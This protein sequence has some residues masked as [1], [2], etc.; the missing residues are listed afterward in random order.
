MPIRE[1]LS[2]RA[3][4]FK[5]QKSGLPIESYGLDAGEKVSNFFLTNAQLVQVNG[6]ASAYEE[7]LLDEP[8]G[9]TSLH[10]FKGAVVAQ[11]GTHLSVRASVASDAAIYAYFDLFSPPSTDHLVST[12]KLFSD[13]WRDRLVLTNSQDARY[14]S[15]TDVSVSLKWFGLDPPEVNAANGPANIFLP[16]AGGNVD[17]GELFY[18]FSLYDADTNTESPCMGSLPSAD[19]LFE[20]SP[21]GF[22]GPRPSSS[23]NNAGSTQ[24]MVC[25]GVTIKALVDAARLI[26]KFRATHFIVYRSGPKVGGLYSSF[27][28]VP[29]KDGGY[30][31]GN[32]IIPIVA[33]QGRSTGILNGQI[34]DFV[35]NTAAASLPAVS[36][37]ENNSPAPTPARLKKSLDFLR[38]Y[39]T[40][41]GANA[42]GP[43]E[44]WALTDYSG[45]RHVRFFRDQLFGIG[46]K[47][48]GFTVGRDISFSSDLKQKVTGLVTNFN[49][50]LHGSE[51]YQPDYFPYRWEVGVGDGQEATALGVLGDVALLCFKEG[52]TYY[53]TGSSPDNYVVRIMDTQKG[54]VHQSTVQETPI[55]VITL[56]RS[57]FILWNKIGQGTPIYDDVHNL[58]EDIHFEHSAQFYSSFDARLNLYRCS[59]AMTGA[60]TN[61][62][63]VTPNLTFVLD[64]NSMQWTI[65]EGSE[66]LCR[67]QFSVN[68]NNLAS[69]EG[70]VMDV[71]KVYDFVGSATNG[72]IF[73]YSMTDNVATN[74]SFPGSAP[75]IANYTSGT[76][77]FGDDQH[78]KRM[79]WVY[80]RAKSFTGWKVNIEII[81]D[82]DESR[83]FVLE[84]W[85]VVSSQSL[86]Y[87]SDVANDGSLLWDSGLGTDDGGRWASDGLVRQVSKIPVSCIGYT[88]QIRIIHQETDPTRYGFAIESLSAEAVQLGR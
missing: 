26:S 7:V 38:A 74:T 17:Q 6:A 24:V 25:L 52:S 12:Q 86:W 30:Y 55:G 21:N 2:S 49:S 22:L 57:G 53:L 41:L 71:G 81:P 27:F 40:Y 19:G 46:G 11:R 32:V 16:V 80:L 28:R 1:R 9:I 35:D 45:F 67:L 29:L 61:N 69:R 20:L 84:N 60:P 64:L 3:P 88:F 79:K 54:C 66:G 23:P 68:S 82:Y 10:G 48:F 72:R 75:I 34:G 4:S 87:S 36:P 47:S 70:V 8:G 18:M 59:V 5:G 31:D 14:L 78:K 76:V 13:A 39:P 50:L 44:D 43:F 33:L 42:F 56:S 37:P 73:D 65:E 83:K 62:Q 51:V 85:D 63:L 58:I 15:Y 77:D